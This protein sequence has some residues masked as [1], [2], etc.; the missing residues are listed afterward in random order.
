[1]APRQAGPGL[2]ESMA[3]CAAAD[4]MYEFAQE[5]EARGHCEGERRQ[6]ERDPHRA[7]RAVLPH[8][9]RPGGAF[10]A[11]RR[12]TICG[13]GGG[14]PMNNVP[15]Y[16]DALPRRQRRAVVRTV[17]RG[18]CWQQGRRGAA[19]A[20]GT[21]RGTALLVVIRRRPG[22]ART[23]RWHRG[24][25]VPRRGPGADLGRL[26][27][28]CACGGGGCGAGAVRATDAAAVNHHVEAGA[29]WNGKQN[30]AEPDEEDFFGFSPG[31]LLPAGGLMRASLRPERKGEGRAKSASHPALRRHLPPLKAALGGCVANH[32]ERKNEKAF[33]EGGKPCLQKMNFLWPEADGALGAPYSGRA[34]PGASQ[35]WNRRENPAGLRDTALPGGVHAAALPAAHRCRQRRAAA[36]SA[37]LGGSRP[38][39][40][41]TQGGGRSARRAGLYGAHRRGRHGGLH[42]AFTSG[43]HTSLYGGNHMK[44]ERKY[45]APLPER[46]LWQRRCQLHP[47]GQRSGGIPP[48]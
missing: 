24:Q 40:W 1:M 29:W 13:S 18:V 6:R 2:A 17:L 47:P 4:A 31:E 10:P 38:R 7:A 35:C 39:A 3:L 48:S 26:A 37:D 46:C 45:M 43:I 28:L 30:E 9:G 42:R 36:G 16:R 15:R 20:G 19:D 14:C 5:D 27:G 25:A 11:T 22:T 44:I 23:I 34:V 8:A 12:A 41:A 21:R 32:A 33:L